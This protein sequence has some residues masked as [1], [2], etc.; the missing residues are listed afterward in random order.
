MILSFEIFIKKD[1]FIFLKAFNY[2]QY[3]DKENGLLL[4][5]IL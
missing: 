4:F 2:I 5:H 1:Y 3:A